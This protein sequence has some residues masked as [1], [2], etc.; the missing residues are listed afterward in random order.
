MEK[1]LAL[2]N[3]FRKGSAVDDPAAWKQHQVTATMVGVFIMALVQL[4]KAFGYDIHID[5]TTATALAGGAIAAVNVVLTYVTSDKI[6][7]LPAKRIADIP[8]EPDSDVTVDTPS[9]PDEAEQ[10]VVPEAAPAQVPE[11]PVEP[12]SAAYIREARAAAIADRA[13]QSLHKGGH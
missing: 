9:V 1:M 3:L 6:G 4:A 12:V 11:Q 13:N 2:L 7:V 8:A 10:P 5:D